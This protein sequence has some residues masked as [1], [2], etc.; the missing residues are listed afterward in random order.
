[1]YME[2]AQD[3]GDFGPSSHTWPCSEEL[4]RPV[5]LCDPSESLLVA[6]NNRFPKYDCVPCSHPEGYILKIVNA[7][8]HPTSPHWIRNDTIKHAFVWKS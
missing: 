4:V 8:H 2:E 5:V 6:L 7:K 3:G 1:M